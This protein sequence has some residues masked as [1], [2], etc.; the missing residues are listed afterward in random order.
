M[1]SLVI[2]ASLFVLVA[3]FVGQQTPTQNLKVD[4]DLVLVNATF[5]DPQDRY[6]VG[7]SKDNFRVWEAKIEQRWILFDGRRSDQRWIDL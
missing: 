2:L 3:P 4:V 1:R 7:L 6:V 5:T